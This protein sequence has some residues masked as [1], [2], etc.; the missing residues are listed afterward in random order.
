MGRRPT[1]DQD[2][3]KPEIIEWISAGKTL[4]DYCRQ[5]GKPTF[6]SI[7]DWLADDADF[8]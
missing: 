4:R 2:A 7:Y 8:A 3:I 5:T 1:Y 6:V